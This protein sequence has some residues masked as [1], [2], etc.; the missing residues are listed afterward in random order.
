MK[1]W[2]I[3]YLSKFGMTKTVKFTG[4][5]MQAALITLETERSDVQ[6]V[7]QVWQGKTRWM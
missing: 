6:G 7:S 3:K 4:R 2:T 1:T 5:T